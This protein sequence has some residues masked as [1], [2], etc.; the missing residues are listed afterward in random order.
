[1]KRYTLSQLT[2]GGLIAAL[3]TLLALALPQF[4]YGPLQFRLSEA[5]TLLPRLLPEAVP[6]LTLGCFL[7][8]LGSPFGLIDIVCG[9]L[10]TALA[11]MITRR[12][13]HNTIIAVAAPILINGFGVSAYVAWLSKELYIAIVPLI[14]GSEAIAVLCLAIPFTAMTR[15]ILSERMGGIPLD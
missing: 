7:A 9:T 11:A 15:R 2:R 14:L 5:L 10:C 3:Y 6:G 13:R 1:M 4:S 12:F 8:N